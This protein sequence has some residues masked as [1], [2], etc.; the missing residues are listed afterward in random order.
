MYRF[1][2]ASADRE[3]R[4]ALLVDLVAH[5]SSEGLKVSAAVAMDAGFELD[6]PGKDSFEHRRAGAREVALA[7]E[8][9]WAIMAE[10]EP[11]RDADGPSHVTDR[12]DD[13]VDL[14]LLSGF[15]GEG[16][17][18]LAV[19]P[20]G[21]VTDVVAWATTVAE[22]ECQGPEGLPHFRLDDLSGIA[23]FILSRC[24]FTTPD[25]RNG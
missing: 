13:S 23:A 10:N 5:L 17:P 16:V 14:L 24:G 4:D 21:E 18:T 22:P 1:N 7:S 15:G 12:M 3:V 25:G 19:A 6:K 20:F 11:G 8:Q 2:L 9:R